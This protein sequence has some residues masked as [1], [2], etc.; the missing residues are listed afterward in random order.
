MR[1]HNFTHKMLL[2]NVIYVLKS[3]GNIVIPII[4]KKKHKF[5][6]IQQFMRKT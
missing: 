1:K 3:K 6:V 2:L 4:Y 5:I